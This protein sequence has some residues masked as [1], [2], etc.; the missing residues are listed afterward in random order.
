MPV[1]RFFPKPCGGNPYCC[2]FHGSHTEEG[3]SR[4]LIPLDNRHTAEWLRFY[5][6][7]G[8]CTP[9]I[10]SAAAAEP[11]RST[12]RSRCTAPQNPLRAANKTN[13][14]FPPMKVRVSSDETPS[15]LGG[16]SEVYETGSSNSFILPHTFHPIL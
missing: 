13:W 5:R 2:I 11:L 6:A 8:S 15:L 14:D 12:P 10:G 3:I 9:R 7:L 4:P 16:N 1:K